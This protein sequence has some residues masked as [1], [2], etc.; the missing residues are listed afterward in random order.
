MSTHP[1]YRA[2]VNAAGMRVGV[3][4]GRFNEDITQ[5]LLDAAVDTLRRCGAADDNIDVVWVPG[6]FEIPVVLEK[7]AINDQYD[8]LIAL[9]CVIRGDTPHFEFV[10]NECARGCGSVARNH[11]I[12]VGFGLLTTD[13]WEQADARAGGMH[14][15]KGEDAVLAAVE[16]AGVLRQL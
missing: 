12:P 10:A 13:T 5:R 11:R 6:A 8:A 14:G 15:N 16:T 7:L 4:I 3:V 1:A 2:D 9:G